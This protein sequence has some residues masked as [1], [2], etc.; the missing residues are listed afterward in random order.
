MLGQSFIYCFQCL[1]PSPGSGLTLGKEFRLIGLQGLSYGPSNRIRVKGCLKIKS[2]TD[3]PY[4][5]LRTLLRNGGKAFLFLPATSG[6]KNLPKNSPKV[7]S[8]SCNKQPKM[9]LLISW[10][11]FKVHCLHGQKL[12]N[13]L[14]WSFCPYM[15]IF[16]AHKTCQNMPIWG[17]KNIFS[18]SF[19]F[20]PY[21]QWKKAI[22]RRF[23]SWHFLY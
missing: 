14:K 2:I 21:R 13:P 1:S 22:L 5:D 15:G 17:H 6:L 4:T 3:R 7:A 19:N 10:S 11:W 16:C 18:G 20:C 8:C 9:A 23:C 12:K